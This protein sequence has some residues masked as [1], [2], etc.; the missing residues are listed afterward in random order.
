MIRFLSLF[1]LFCTATIYAMDWKTPQEVAKHYASIKN[2]SQSPI[3]PSLLDPDRTQIAESQLATKYMQQCV[4]LRWPV[5]F[6]T[7]YSTMRKLNKVSESTRIALA[8]EAINWAQEEC[9]K[10]SE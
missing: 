3:S 6:V 1:I 5:C 2:L 4:G 7:Y 8:G 9:T 10:D